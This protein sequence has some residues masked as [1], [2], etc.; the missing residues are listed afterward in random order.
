[1]RGDYIAHFRGR[2]SNNLDILGVFD[3][4]RTGFVHNPAFTWILLFSH[5][6]RETK[7][8]LI[9]AFLVATEF[10]L[11]KEADYWGDFVFDQRFALFVSH[12]G[13]VETVY[14]EE[15][16]RI[17]ADSWARPYSMAASPH[18]S[19][20]LLFYRPP[21]LVIYVCGVV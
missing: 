3:Q 1:M 13:V 11:G 7:N 15:I 16:A 6:F 12:S 17:E 19:F 18:F 8:T 10:V 14:L 21:S 9:L 4:H 2:A 20:N 5:L